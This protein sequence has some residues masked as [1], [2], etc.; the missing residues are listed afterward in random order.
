MRGR[1]TLVRSMAVAVALAAAF[2]LAS[3]ALW[4]LGPDAPNPVIARV[5][6]GTDDSAAIAVFF[7]DD[8]A[9]R[10]SRISVAI[11][12][13]R[14]CPDSLILLIG[15][16]RPGRNYYG[17]EAMSGELQIAGIPKARLRAE[18]ASYDTASN[19][20]ELA[21][22]ADADG[23]SRLILVSDPFH[24]L[25]IRHYF[26]R[27]SRNYELSAA[28]SGAAAAWPHI[29]WR[30]AYESCAWAGMLLPETLRQKLLGLAGRHG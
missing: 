8:P 7:S 22:L 3:V 14:E 5:L 15:G 24:L 25:R 16:A 26:A 12:A 23:I 20:S 29:V 21:R 30:A 2:C 28:A 13:A 4:R 6:C 9:D 17:A 11:E 18:R 27:S 10:Q 19:V 1:S